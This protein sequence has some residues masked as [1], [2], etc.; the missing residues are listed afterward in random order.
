MRIDDLICRL[1]RQAAVADEPV[2]HPNLEDVPDSVVA[3][4]VKFL[5]AKGLVTGEL[6]VACNNQW[7]L[8][9]GLRITRSGRAY[10]V[11][12]GEGRDARPRRS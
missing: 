3:K 12:V 11:S 8:E 4:L 7:I 2:T 10:L 5:L 9:P 6:Y 1:L